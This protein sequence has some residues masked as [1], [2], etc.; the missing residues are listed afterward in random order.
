[1]NISDVNSYAYFQGASPAKS[2][3]ASSSSSSGSA[4]SSASGASDQTSGGSVQTTDFTHMTRAGLADWVNS[5][6]KSGQMSLDDSTAFVSMTVKI[7]VG[8]TYTGLDGQE[9]VNFMQT[10]QGGIT[11]AQ[12]NN[13]PAMVEQLQAALGVMQKNQGQTTGVNLTA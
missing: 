7:P 1:M 12:Q 3:K 9:S 11:W 2:A 4:L 5:Q 6:I 13:D 10:A 8:G